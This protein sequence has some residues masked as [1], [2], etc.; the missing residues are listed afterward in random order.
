[1]LHPRLPRPPFVITDIPMT[2]D[3]LREFLTVTGEI[4][5]DYWTDDHIIDAT[6][7]DEIYFCI[8]EYWDSPFFRY[9]KDYRPDIYGRVT[10]YTAAFIMQRCR[11]PLYRRGAPHETQDL[12]STD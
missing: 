2:F 12:S 10:H 9:H 5:D 3:G 4:N 6:E 1:M 8:P 7:S 11:P